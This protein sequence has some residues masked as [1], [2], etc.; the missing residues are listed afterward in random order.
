MMI[1]EVAHSVLMRPTG[2]SVMR[3]KML[4]R[5]RGYTIWEANP[6]RQVGAR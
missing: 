4:K 3:I 5:A 2:F 1:H 6:G